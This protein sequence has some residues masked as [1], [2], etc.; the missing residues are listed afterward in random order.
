M[1]TLR[2]L[3]TAQWF[4]FQPLEEALDYVSNGQSTFDQVQ[5]FKDKA[6][7]EIHVFI[8]HSLPVERIAKTAS[9]VLHGILMEWLHPT[10]VV[11]LGHHNAQTQTRVTELLRLLATS[12]VGLVPGQDP[13]GDAMDKVVDDVI[14]GEA[15]RV[16]WSGRTSIVPKLRKWIEDRWAPAY[17]MREGVLN[18]TMPWIGKDSVDQHDMKRALST[19]EARIVTSWQA[20]AIERLGKYRTKHLF[21]YVKGW[22][23]SQGAVLDIKVSA[24]SIYYRECHTDLLRKEWLRSA[25]VVNGRE[26]KTFVIDSFGQQLSQRILHAGATTSEILSIYI[27]IIYVFKTLD[28]RGVLLDKVAQEVRAYLR[29]REDTVKVIAASFLADLD[30]DEHLDASEISDEVCEDIAR[31]LLHSYGEDVRSS[32]KALDWDD[33]EW[34]PDPIDAGP[35]F[36]RNKNEDII[37]YMLTLFNQADFIKELQNILGERLLKSGDPELE[38]EFRLV[39]L[40]KARFGQDKLQAC[41]VMLRDMRDSRDLHSSIRHRLPLDMPS[42]SEIRAAI[43]PQ[44]ISVSDFVRQ[45]RGRIGNNPANFQA[46]EDRISR[47]AET[48]GAQNDALAL[49]DLALEELES[50]RKDDFTT[51][52][53]ALV[54]SSFFWPSLRDDEFAI[55]APIQQLQAA[56]AK[57]FER[58]KDTRKLAWQP[59]L[60]HATVELHLADR[61]VKAEN[62]TTWAASVIYAFQSDHE[63]PAT[64]TVE[65]LAEQLDMDD[66]LVRNAL[67]F[68]VA[69]TVLFETDAETYTVLETLV[70][71]DELLAARTAGPATAAAA[72][73]EVSAVKTQ[74]AILMENKDMYQMFMVGMLT[75]GGAMDI[76]R[77][78]MMMKMVCPGGFAFGEQEVR[79]LLED[80]AAQGKVAEGAGGAFA[81]KK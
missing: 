31:E 3:S 65:Q 48:F 45:F 63:E 8:Q 27:N 33:M 29:E 12:G 81:I 77:V 14:R 35:D 52:F 20:S 42:L 15:F 11:G 44:G 36:R 51:S 2:I 13:F 16:D 46:F 47:V 37:S 74:D 21:D 60:G 59:A 26:A 68:W 10:D 72:V 78:T 24:C 7:H 56:Y 73:P 25:S 22:D 40:F 17:Y 53:D 62:V 43:P 19:D 70:Q 23:W 79:W 55:P 75:N 28:P 58:V 57:E 9:F 18:G 54:Q 30:E 41:E 76:A 38:K 5:V 64:R 32:S 67:A 71:K 69:Q 39:E 1:Q 6:M 50:L 34:M 80:M 61:S 4:W 66:L 49:K